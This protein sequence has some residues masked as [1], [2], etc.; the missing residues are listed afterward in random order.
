MKRTILTTLAATALLAIPACKGGA[1]ASGGKLIPEQATIMAGIDVGGLLKS[2]LYADN[3]A[4]AESQAGYKEVV[5]AAKACNLD[6]EKA[7][8]SV[9]IGTDAKDGVAVVVTGAGIGDEKNLTC[10]AGKAK[11]K[12]NGKSFTIVD[13]G[14]KKTIKLDDGEGTGYIV[15]AGTIVIASKPWAAAVKDLVD[16]KGKA[17]VD[18]PHKDLFTRAD[19]SRHIWFA[20]VAPEQLA[21]MAKAQGQVDVKD[22]SGSID[23]SDGLGVKLA[24]GLGSAEQASGLKKKADEALPMA[25]MGLAMVG[26]PATVADTVKIDAKDTLLSFEISLSASD[27]KTLQE[28]AGGLGGL[29]GGGAPSPAEPA[30]PPPAADPAAAP[31]PAAPAEGAPPAAPAH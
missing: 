30:I 16:G 15:D 19:Q 9:L 31:P 13:E 3:K 4:V 17:A 6:P 29:V 23:L 20:G 5:E 27:L 18:G 24:A 12:N 21:G 26:L 10:I 25:K 2:K 14:G 28:K 1:S 8:N 22:F 7:I 11:E